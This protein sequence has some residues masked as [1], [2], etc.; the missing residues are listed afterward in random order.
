[1]VSNNNRHADQWNTTESSEI[2][3]HNYELHQ[4][5]KKQT[6]GERIVS[7]INGTEKNWFSTCGR[8]K[9]DP[10]LTTYTKINSIWIE[11]LN[12]R[13]ETIQQSEQNI[14]ENLVDIGLGN[15]DSDMPPKA[16]TTKAKVEDRISSN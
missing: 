5:C 16:Q 2:N 3:P 7:S 4:R 14:G 12:V 10:Y 13:P 9:L 6:I 11:D 15:N 8:M 1:M